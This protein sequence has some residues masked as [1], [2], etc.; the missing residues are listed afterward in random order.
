M[1]STRQTKSWV[2]DAVER[3]FWTA[4]EAVVAAAVVA[5]T[6][7]VGPEWLPVFT[8]A[9]AAVKVVIAKHVGSPSSAAITP[10]A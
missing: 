7:H 3:V 1:A 4:A 6:P 10:V 5:V 8:A 2:S 9:A